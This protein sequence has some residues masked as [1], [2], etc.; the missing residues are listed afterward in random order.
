MPRLANP[1]VWREATAEEV[2]EHLA[3]HPIYH[4]TTC[5]PMEVRETSEGVEVLDG[6]P[7]PCGCIPHHTYMRGMWGFYCETEQQ[8]YCNF[9]CYHDQ[10]D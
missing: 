3:G 8:P 6:D 7:A 5:E 4:E 2:A 9:E 1:P 10:E